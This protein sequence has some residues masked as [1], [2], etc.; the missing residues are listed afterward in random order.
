MSEAFTYGL[1]G[2]KGDGEKRR[3]GEVVMGRKGEVGDGANE[4]EN[5]RLVKSEAT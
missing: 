2:G 1:G 5:K 3:R 4:G